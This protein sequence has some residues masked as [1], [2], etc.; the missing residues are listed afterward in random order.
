[1]GGAGS[2]KAIIAA[3]FAFLKGFRCEV[4]EMIDLNTKT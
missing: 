1:V 3:P 4:S 2:V